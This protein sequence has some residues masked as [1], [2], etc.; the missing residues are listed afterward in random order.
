MEFEINREFTTKEFTN[1]LG[2]YS[3]RSV[4]GED[5]IPYHFLKKLGQPFVEAIAS[6]AQAS[7]K[8]GH[9]PRNLKSALTVVLR[10]PG[11]PSYEHT[12]A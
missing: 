4:P 7:W 2:G 12:K 10:K 6:L 1:L 9:M 3:D 11:K 8:L 5:Q